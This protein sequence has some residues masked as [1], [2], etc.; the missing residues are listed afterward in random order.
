HALRSKADIKLESEKTL[1]EQ[2]DTA[3]MTLI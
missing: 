2:F 3:Q 1:K